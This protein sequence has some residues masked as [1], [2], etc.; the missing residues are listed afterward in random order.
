MQWQPIET[1]P[2][3]EAGEMLGPT[4]LIYYDADGL[5]WPAYWG[6]CPGAPA[7]G[8]WIPCD[9]SQD[10]PFHTPDVNHWMP[11]PTPPNGGSDAE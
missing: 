1:A 11:L 2:K 10:R 7:E 3:N 4:I 8:A 9:D 5:P 6:P